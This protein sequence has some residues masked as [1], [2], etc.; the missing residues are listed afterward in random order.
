MRRGAGRS[1]G[2]FDVIW[3]SYWAGFMICPRN[4]LVWG[5]GRLINRADKLCREEGWMDPRGFL[6]MARE[7]TTEK[8]E[9]QDLVQLRERMLRDL[10]KKIKKL[11]RHRARK[12]AKWEVRWGTWKERKIGSEHSYQSHKRRKSHP[13]YKYL[14]EESWMTPKVSVLIQRTKDR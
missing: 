5:G 14:E 12:F 3:W 8:I 1:H 11:T 13:R 9:E 2:G 10:I 4:V 6:E 7:Q